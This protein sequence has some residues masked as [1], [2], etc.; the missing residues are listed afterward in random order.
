MGW[1]ERGITNH[2]WVDIKYA[3]SSRV[4]VWCIDDLHDVVIYVILTIRCDFI[5]DLNQEGEHRDLHCK[6]RFTRVN[7]FPS[8]LFT[9]TERTEI[10]D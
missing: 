9:L 2:G 5:F 8:K 1:E 10:T 6:D 3:A 4:G 7:Y